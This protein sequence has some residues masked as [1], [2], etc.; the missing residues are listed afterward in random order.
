[1]NRERWC[2]FPA[3][4]DAERA[5]LA[6]VSGTRERRDLRLAGPGQARSLLGA[7]LAI[8]AVGPFDGKADVVARLTFDGDGPAPGERV[9][10]DGWE[11]LDRFLLEAV[12]AARRAAER[13]R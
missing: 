13:E 3:A 7:T 6:S 4:T 1:M 11:L 8:E 10:E 12:A 2:S 9:A 5:I